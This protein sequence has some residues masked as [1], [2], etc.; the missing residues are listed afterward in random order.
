[1]KPHPTEYDVLSKWNSPSFDDITRAVLSQRLHA[2]PPRRFFDDEQ[3]ALV[4]ALAGRLLPQPER[5]EP[6]ALTPWIDAMLFENRGEGFRY[7]QMPPLRAAWRLGLAA[8]AAEARLRHDT[9][10]AALSPQLQDALL[11]DIAGGLVH[12][13]CWAGLDAQ[14]FFSQ[15]LLK[16]LAGIYYA[17]P[18][19]WNEIGFGGPASPRGYVRLGFDQR[20]GWEAP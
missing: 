14:R 7:E 20:D 16:S 2:I 11:A 12:R 9:P 17:H 19:A 6:I 5:S 3:W 4:D 1:V 13:A 18:A 8:I 15:L 10:F